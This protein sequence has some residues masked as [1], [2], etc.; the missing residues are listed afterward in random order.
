[1]S[2]CTESD[3]GRQDIIGLTVM[4]LVG[5]LS[6]AFV[7]VFFGLVLRNV[8][9]QRR[10]PFQSHLDIYLASLF[11]ADIFRGLTAA[12][13]WR[14]VVTGKVVCGTHC[15]IQGALIQFGSAGVSLSTL[16][17]L[18]FDSSPCSLRAAERKNTRRFQSIHFRSYF[19]Y[20]RHHFPNG[21][22]YASY[23]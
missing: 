7:L 12:V 11:T 4:A 5:S 20:G 9:I 18:N 15:N 21:L 2:A 3:L 1:M 16:A 13:N 6:I 19:S 17:S 14:W 10:H 22:Q 8:F 23:H